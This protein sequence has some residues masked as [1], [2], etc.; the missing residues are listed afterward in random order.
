MATYR[1][2]FCKA[3]PWTTASVRRAADGDCT[4]VDRHRRRQG[5]A[6]RRNRRLRRELERAQMM[7]RVSAPWSRI[8]AVEAAVWLFSSQRVA[9]RFQ[10]PLPRASRGRR[11]PA[12]GQELRTGHRGSL[13]RQTAWTPVYS[14]CSQSACGRQVTRAPYPAL[15]FRQSEAAPRTPEDSRFGSRSRQRHSAGLRRRSRVH[16]HPRLRRSRGPSG[17]RG[18][19]S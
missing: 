8:S 11:Q 2:P 7:T 4:A 13:P 18:H 19:G 6:R 3:E 17:L 9:S 12:A 10:L 14:R 1:R 16:R 5:A 15:I